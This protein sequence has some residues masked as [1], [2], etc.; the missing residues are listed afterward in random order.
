MTTLYFIEDD[1]FIDLEDAKKRQR[2]FVSASI[3][4]IE[5]EKT[6]DEFMVDYEQLRKEGNSIVDSIEWAK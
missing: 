5:T 4:T 2:Q 1:F 6:Y 3:D